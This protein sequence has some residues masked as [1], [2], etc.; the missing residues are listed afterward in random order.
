MIDKL[1]LWS[2]PATLGLLV[3]VT[4]LP[5]V[6]AGAWWVRVWDFPRLQIVFLLLLPLGLTVGHALRNPFHSQHAAMLVVIAA[7]AAWQLTHVAPFTPLWRHEVPDATDDAA[8]T[9][10]LLTANID[11]KNRRYDDVL[12][13]FLEEDPD[14]LLVVEVDKKWA[15]ALTPL[16][17]RY[18]HRAGV[19]RDKGLGIV[20]WSRLPLN[21]PEVRHLVSDERASIFATVELSDGA[22]LRFVGI[23]P[24]PPGLRESHAERKHAEEDGDDDDDRHDSRVRDAE[25]VLVAREAR[26]DHEPRW[27]VTGDFNDVAWSHTTRLFQDL[28]ALKDPRRGRALM[29]TYPIKWPPCRFPI[30]HVFVSDGLHLA[31]MNRVMTPG[32]DHFAIQATFAL[33]ERDHTAPDASA[34]DHEEAEELVD[35]GKEDAAE[36]ESVA[37]E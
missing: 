14:L 31:S 24:T 1:L 28:S 7:V 36:R 2:A 33:A 30:D 8:T 19:V 35:E 17:E 18:P 25:L 4:L 16:D 13:M 37:P 34:E 32:S 22:P 20:L 11:Y 9:F 5:L 21:D 10:K 23:H 27:I 26:R 3:L 29:N 15:T 12:A 6:P